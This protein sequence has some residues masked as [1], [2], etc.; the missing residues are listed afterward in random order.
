[1]APESQVLHATVV[2]QDSLDSTLVLWTSLVVSGHKG[3]LQHS[4]L[5]AKRESKR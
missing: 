5:E 1:M 2:G 3:L 4:L